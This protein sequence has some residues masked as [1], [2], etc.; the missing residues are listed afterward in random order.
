MLWVTE[1][2]GASNA[3]QCK[4]AEFNAPSLPSGAPTLTEQD[5]TGWEAKGALWTLNSTRFAV[6]DA[7]HVLNDHCFVLAIDGMLVSSGVVLSSYSARRITFPTISVSNQNL[8]VTLQLNSGH[9]G[10]RSQPIHVS[11]L[12]SILALRPDFL[13]PPAGN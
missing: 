5:V 4:L 8:A 3:T 7:G 12:N 10:D 11:A 1:S 6:A 9:Q 13:Q 2:I